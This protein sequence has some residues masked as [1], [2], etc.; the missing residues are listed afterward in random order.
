MRLG[1]R[2]GPTHRPL[3]RLGFWILAL[4]L[5]AASSAEKKK[6]EPDY[7]PLRVK[8]WWE[9]RLTQATGDSSEIRLTVVS[10]RSQPDGTVRSCIEL[11]NPTPV[12]RDWYTKTP[13]EVV[14]NE[15]EYLGG[16]G[17]VALD[18]PRPMLRFPLAPGASWTWNGTAR[19][20]TEVYERSQ[21][22]GT[23]KVEVPAGRFDAVKI[24]T[25]I[26]QGGAA[27]TKTSW[28]AP[29]VGL[30]R[31][32]TESAGVTSVTELLDYS[33]KPKR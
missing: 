5:A 11:T 21:V 4:T 23:E 24:E 13:A 18:P 33:F 3:L 32:A 7:F 16:G 30:V 6:K 29:N 12:F 8:D 1:L 2:S 26:R 22:R 17:K 19:A 10:E 31:Q 14:L 20:N 27:A 25:E 9:Y 28:F 15:E